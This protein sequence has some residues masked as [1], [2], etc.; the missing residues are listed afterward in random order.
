MY[1]FN[2]SNLQTSKTKRLSLLYLSMASRAE[3]LDSDETTLQAALQ[4]KMKPMQI[5]K[6][7]ASLQKFSPAQVCA[8]I[9]NL[10][11]KNRNPD[12]KKAQQKFVYK[13][14]KSIA[15]LMKV[16]RVKFLATKSQRNRRK[17][18]LVSQKKSLH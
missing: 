8:K 15:W 9:N 18:M 14:S 5:W 2:H 10:K 6:S 16:N 4:K 7:F 1:E 3:W 17:N 11:R 13:V 12:K